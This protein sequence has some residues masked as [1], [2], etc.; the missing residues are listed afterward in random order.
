M[1]FQ[2]LTIENMQLFVTVADSGSISAAAEQFFIDPS[3]VSRKI[4]LME[5]GLSNQLFNRS[6]RGVSLTDSGS[7]FYKF[8]QETL[9]NLSV[10]FDELSVKSELSQLRIGTYDSVSVG[11]YNNFFSKNF[12]KL[13]TVTISNQI[14]E[15]IKNFNNNQL[16]TLIIDHEFS[17]LLTDTF[18]EKPLIEEAF[19][20]VSNHKFTDRFV[21][22]DWSQLELFLH[23]KNCPIHQKLLTV[24]SKEK[25]PKIHEIE[26]TVS[27]LAFL[28]SKNQATLLPESS[29]KKVASE[30]FYFYKLPEKFNRKLSLVSRNLQIQDLFFKSK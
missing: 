14:N 8:C 4:S 30:N 29:L 3:S 27:A 18:Y 2:H 11:L 17:K 12:S 10:L 19:Y 26:H 24:C 20:L 15:L 9:E 6:T 1:S 28:N 21:S 23:P 25:L 22:K 7:N 5:E 16:N 13:G